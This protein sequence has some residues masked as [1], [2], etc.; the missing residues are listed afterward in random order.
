M[1]PF[2]T[3]LGHLFVELQ[4]KL[5]EIGYEMSTPT[6]SI[7]TERWTI[8]VTRF[9]EPIE[10]NWAYP[11]PGNSMRV[12]IQGV[13]LTRTEARSLRAHLDGLLNEGG[14]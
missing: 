9:E 4:A 12:A 2:R 7:E 1:S 11:G 5:A 14:R 8:E 6:S 13:K 3:P 10:I